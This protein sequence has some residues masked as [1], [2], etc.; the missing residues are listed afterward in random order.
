MRRRFAI[1]ALSAMLGGVFLAPTVAAGAEEQRSW[2]EDCS[3]YDVYAL[4]G[5][6]EEQAEPT[7]LTNGWEGAILSRTFDA[8]AERP[9]LAEVTNITTISP[10]MGYRAVDPV[11][12]AVSAAFEGGTVTNG[13]LWN[14]YDSATE[15]TMAAT[16]ELLTNL[17]EQAAA[18]CAP[19]QVLFGYS[20]GAV[21]TRLAADL[22]PGFIEKVLVV[23]DMA[24]TANPVI[25]GTGGDSNGIFYSPDRTPGIATGTRGIVSSRV[26]E[27]KDTFAYCTEGDNF[28]ST[29]PYWMFS[30]DNW[31]HRS[32]F[33]DDKT[34]ATDIREWF[35]EWDTVA[36]TYP[37]P[38]RYTPPTSCS[39]MRSAEWSGPLY[40]TE[41]RS[42]GRGAQP[43]LWNLANFVSGPLESNGWLFCGW[44]NEPGADGH[45]STLVASVSPEFQKAQLAA[46]ESQG[47]ECVASRCVLRVQDAAGAEYVRDVAFRG[48]LMVSTSSWGTPAAGYT[49]SVLRTIT[50]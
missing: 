21:A 25:R 38:R 18:G 34:G 48:N 30:L 13:A 11:T 8:L 9:E 5:S 50:K 20:Q 22:V 37:F 1:I 27:D 47:A 7:S 44:G 46:L 29:T 49:D 17:R 24:Q 6:G 32:Y 40:R 3:A 45:V 14:I 10:D 36:P 26:Y 41:D 15:G 2:G 43:S 12:A 19:N 31:E 42:G 35:S 4:R 16:T 33:T 28:C 23:G 39:S